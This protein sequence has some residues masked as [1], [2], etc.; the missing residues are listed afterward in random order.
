LEIV[1]PSE[2]IFPLMAVPRAVNAPTTAIA[3]NAAATAYSDSSRP[4]S[5][6]KN[7]LII[8]FAPFIVVDAD[9]RLLA[10]SLKKAGERGV[11]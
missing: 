7:L 10:S 5:S 3:T 11:Y 9:A 2:V 4:V 1:V 8:L 6:R